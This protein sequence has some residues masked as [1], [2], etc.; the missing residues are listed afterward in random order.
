[1]SQSNNARDA[2]NGATTRAQRGT[3]LHHEHE[4]T[5]R[6]SSGVVFADIGVD[7]ATGTVGG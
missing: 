4:N 1:M 7:D 3:F 6:F 5:K 2:K